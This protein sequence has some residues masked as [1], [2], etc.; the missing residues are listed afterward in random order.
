MDFTTWLQQQGLTAA[1]LSQEELSSWYPKYQE[2][3]NRV[4]DPN[5]LLKPNAP[6]AG[7]A[8]S[9]DP[10]IWQ[11][12]DGTTRD[13]WYQDPT[14]GYWKGPQQTPPGTTSDQTNTVG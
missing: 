1:D 2:A 4:D 6:G 8:P 9:S 10:A 5:G 7:I 12:P 3:T 13:G 11:N 14:T